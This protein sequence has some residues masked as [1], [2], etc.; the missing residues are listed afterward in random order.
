MRFS[1]HHSGLISTQ[2]LVPCKFDQLTSTCI[3]SIMGYYS[4][5]L[6]REENLDVEI[7]KWPTFDNKVPV[8]SRP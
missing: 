5:F 8:D 2:A 6:E 7:D 4:K 3:T 1:D